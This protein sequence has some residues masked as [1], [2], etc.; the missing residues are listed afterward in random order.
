VSLF[1]LPII[2]QCYLFHFLFLDVIFRLPTKDHLTIYGMS[3]LLTRL[4]KSLGEKWIDSICFCYFIHHHHY[5]H[6]YIAEASPSIREKL[7]LKSIFQWSPKCPQPPIKGI[8]PHR[9]ISRSA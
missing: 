6:Q 8:F 5:R 4:S 3:P 2:E 7:C 9:M 1:V